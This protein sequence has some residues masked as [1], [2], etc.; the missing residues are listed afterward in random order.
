MRLDV[1]TNLAAWSDDDSVISYD[2]IGYFDVPVGP[3]GDYGN[4]YVTSWALVM[5][6]GSENKEAAWEFIKW[7]T[8][9]EM[10]IEAQQNGNSGARN[11]CWEENYIIYP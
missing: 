10:Q 5:S 3:N 8:S 2:E 11:S 6:S 9:K 7:A 4:Y 1:N